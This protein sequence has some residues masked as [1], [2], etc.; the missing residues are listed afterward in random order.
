M[1]YVVIIFYAYVCK[2][3]MYANVNSFRN[4]AKNIMEQNDLLGK[5]GFL[6]KEKIIQKKKKKEF[7]LPVAAVRSSA[8]LKKV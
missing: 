6:K 7:T 8:R 3:D 4:R 2:D 1:K 5:L